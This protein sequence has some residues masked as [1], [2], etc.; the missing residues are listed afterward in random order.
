[1]AKAISGMGVQAATF[2]EI[3]TVRGCCHLAAGWLGNRVAML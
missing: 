3:G 1:M 2:G